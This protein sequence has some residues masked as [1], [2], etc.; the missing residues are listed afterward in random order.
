VRHAFDTLGLSKRKFNKVD[1]RKWSEFNQRWRCEFLT[2]IHMRT[3]IMTV[4]FMDE[5]HV[6]LLQNL[7]TWWPRGERSRARVCVRACLCAR[8]SATRRAQRAACGVYTHAGVPIGEKS[9]RSEMY[10]SKDTL[11]INAIIGLV[12]F[13]CTGCVL[14]ALERPTRCTAHRH[15]VHGGLEPRDDAHGV[16][17]LQRLRLHPVKAPG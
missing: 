3:D 14:S 1:P 12:P 9:F 16:R 13:A 11:T 7:W 8:G 4:F 6:T 17:L 15:G 5:T 10:R 2:E